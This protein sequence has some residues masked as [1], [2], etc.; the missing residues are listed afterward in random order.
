MILGSS[1]LWPALAV[2]PSI[3]AMFPNWRFSCRL[4]DD[5]VEDETDVR[6]GLLVDSFATASI[7]HGAP[8][9]VPRTTGPG[10]VRDE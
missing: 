4:V 6:F 9:D 7:E 5:F 1:H 3:G 2:T 10:G 8:E